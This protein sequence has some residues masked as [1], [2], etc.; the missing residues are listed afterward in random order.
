MIRDS[1]LGLGIVRRG[2]LGLGQGTRTLRAVIALMGG[3]ARGMSCLVSWLQ[4]T[5]PSFPA[6]ESDIVHDPTKHPCTALWEHTRYQVRS[7]LQEQ[8]P[9]HSIKRTHAWHRVLWWLSV[10]DLFIYLFIYLFTHNIPY[11]TI[12]ANMFNCNQLKML[13]K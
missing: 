6:M 2:F 4:T 9:V 13:Y 3:S 12:L 7:M 1:C 5:P 8:A 11:I 10:S